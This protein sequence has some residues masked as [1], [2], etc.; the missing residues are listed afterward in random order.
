VGRTGGLEDLDR[1]LRL[2][3]EPSLVR[4]AVLA[5]LSR[6]L[7][8]LGRWEE[9][10]PINEET[11]TLSERF[12]EECTVADALNNLAIAE[13]A[14]GRF[15]EAM[16]LL[17]TARAR[18]EHA[19]D[20]ETMVRSMVN[21][22]DALEAGGE[23]EAAVE[24]AQRAVTLAESLGR[25]R[26]QGISAANNLTEAQIT[27]GRWDDAIETFERAI[28][29]CLPPGLRGVHLLN[30]GQIAALRGEG[31]V[32]A[33]FVDELRA[34]AAIDDPY[35]QQVLPLASLTIEWRLAEGDV[36]GAIEATRRAIT[37]HDL[38]RDVRHTWPILVAGMR[39][40]AA[41]P[42]VAL[43]RRIQAIADATPAYGPVMAARRATVAAESSR[44]GGDLDQS[45]WDDVASAWEALGSPHPLAY[46]LLRSAEAAVTA[47]ARDEASARLS[48]AA[49]IADRLGAKPLR[50]EI[51][52]LARRSRITLAG[53][54]PEAG[55]PVF[56]LTAREQEVLRLVAEGRSNRD[57]AEELFISAKTA[58]VHVS[59]ILGKLG[60]ASRGEAAATAHRLRL[61]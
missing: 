5:P 58:S 11:L 39:A 52:L 60:V 43:A 32:A 15:A 44:A 12:D 53:A 37:E 59:N 22:S 38:A 50:A 31:E 42:D 1:A 35:P 6:A 49:E 33:R 20:G 51:G 46:A 41:Q 47:G 14:E 2:V 4:V 27:L 34:L 30:R 21:Q 28:E 29:L 16:A 18:A 54:T 3:P 56:G 7:V 23:S 61:V 26:T 9:A 19:H 36:P 17:D 55:R 8:L 45:A 25:A 13:A 48:R 57:I 40:C 10:R 24:T